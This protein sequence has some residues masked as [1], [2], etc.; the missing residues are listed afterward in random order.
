[1][2][3][4][5]WASN[6]IR[7]AHKNSLKSPIKKKETKKVVT[8]SVKI[9]RTHTQS[10]PTGS[11]LRSEPSSAPIY[12]SNTPVPNNVKVDVFREYGDFTLIKYKLQ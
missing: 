6:Y 1:M 12:I 9:R 5:S 3:I 11:L 10:H 2:S 8:E 4:T 7:L